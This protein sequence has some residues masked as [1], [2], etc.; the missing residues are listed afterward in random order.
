MR[1]I[2]AWLSEYGESHRDRTNKLIHWVCVP[3]IVF[4]VV[5]IIWSIPWPFGGPP[6]PLLNW[7]TLGLVAALIYYVRLSV[8]LAAGMLLISAAMVGVLTSL[9]HQDIPVLKLSLLL[10]VVAWIGQFIG[11]KIEGK[12]PSFF[13]DIQFLLI[14]PLWVLSY[15]YRRA[16]IP[17]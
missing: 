8:P 4:S 15:L 16:G 2:D 3:T 7:A 13:K 17:Y 10:F 11:H 5:G 1:S 6:S 12:K 9:A 14:G